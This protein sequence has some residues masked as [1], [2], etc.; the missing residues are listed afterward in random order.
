VNGSVRQAKREAFERRE[1]ALAPYGLA[2]GHMSDLTAHWQAKRRLLGDSRV[3]PRGCVHPASMPA[4]RTSR[5]NP[6]L[7]TPSVIA[8]RRLLRRLPSRRAAQWARYQNS[9][10][11][12]PNRFQSCTFTCCPPG[13]EFVQA[14]QRDLL[15]DANL[16]P[17]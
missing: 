1:S 5:S 13:D 8:T 14:L 9:P 4:R 15:K 6:S 10:T 7:Q 16:S 2:S 3:I 11:M 12:A 17:R